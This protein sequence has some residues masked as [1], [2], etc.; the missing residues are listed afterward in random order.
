[1]VKRDMFFKI[2]ILV[3]AIGLLFS[4]NTLHKVKQ[5]CLEIKENKNAGNDYQEIQNVISAHSYHYEAQAQKEEIDKFWSKRDDIAYGSMNLTRQQTIDYYYGSN[6]KAR[7]AKLE[8]MSKLYPDIKN[9]PKNEGVGDMVLHL[10]TT[11]YIVIAKDGKTAKGLWY[12]PAL[13]VEIGTEGKPVPTVMMEKDEADFI[14][15]DGQWKIWHFQQWPLF[16]TAVDKSVVD[17]SNPGP[18][19]TAGRI[20]SA[21]AQQPAMQSGQGMPAMKGAAEPYS[22]KRIAKFLPNLPQSY[23]TWDDS[24]SCVNVK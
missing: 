7:K 12:S 9:V 4:W 14:K 3:L 6:Q 11:P 24:M 22:A 20:T 17:G 23:D 10:T 16:T 8:L 5:E 13:C 21:S 2:A 19:R 18:G 1:M 15:E